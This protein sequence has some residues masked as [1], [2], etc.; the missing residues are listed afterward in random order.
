MIIY[1]SILYLIVMALQK[2]RTEALLVFFCWSTYLFCEELH[3]LFE[4]IV[5]DFY[6]GQMLSDLFNILILAPLLLNIEGRKI[7]LP[8]IY[9]TSIFINMCIYMTWANS[10]LLLS[11]YTEINFILFELIMYLCI[12]KELL[13][14]TDLGDNLFRWAK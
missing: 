13:H 4:I 14:L 12:E 3:I 5:G 8:L 10:H 1:Y 7:W 6:V 2:N 11:Y 9:L